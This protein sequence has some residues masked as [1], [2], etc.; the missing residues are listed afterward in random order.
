[1]NPPWPQRN[2]AHTPVLKSEVLSFLDVR[3]GGI[4]L[5]GT[6]GLGGHASAIQ[7]R[8]SGEGTLVGLDGDGEALERCEA[9]LSPLPTCHLVHDS[10]DRFSHHLESLGIQGV[11]GMLLDLGLSSYQLDSPER[12]FS[13]RTDGPL[14]MRFNTDSTLTAEEIVNRWGE[15]RL[16]EIIRDLGEEREARKIARAI[17]ERRESQPIATTFQ[18]RDIVASQNPGRYMTKTLSR[19]FQALRIVVNRELDSLQQ[20]LENFI[21]YLKVG[22]RLVVISYHS[23]EDRMVKMKIKELARGCI[24]PPELP[25]CQCGKEPRVKILTPRPVTPHEGEI[26]EN[27]RSRSAKLR[28]AE[29]TG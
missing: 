4:Y 1:M 20:F 22:G 27:A 10:Y 8:L 21:D 12:G 18:L 15:R 3:P 26:R 7:S 6:I 14:D 24:C 19:V 13:Y 25:V 23:L 16:R 9:S 5:D 28:A 17:V 29:K 2:P 11:D